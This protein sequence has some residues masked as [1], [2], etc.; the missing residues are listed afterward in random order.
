MQ[1]VLTG[2]KC[3]VGESGVGEEEERNLRVACYGSQREKAEQLKLQLG[4]QDVSF[5]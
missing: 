4:V 1:V 2:R 5:Y 3:G